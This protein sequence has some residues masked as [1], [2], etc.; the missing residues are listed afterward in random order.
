ML[1]FLIVPVRRPSSS[2]FDRSKIGV[3]L[4]SHLEVTQ[5][6][7]LDDQVILNPSDSLASGQTVRIRSSQNE[8]KKTAATPE[9]KH[10]VDL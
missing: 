6:L 5:G 8:K 2:A 4:G 10:S 1:A 3:D 9:A 7:S